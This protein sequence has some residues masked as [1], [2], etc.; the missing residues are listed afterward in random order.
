MARCETC[1]CLHPIITLSML[2]QCT[3]SSRPF[4]PSTP[5]QDTFLTCLS[6][7]PI[8]RLF[9]QL[10]RPGWNP[11]EPAL[12]PAS[13]CTLPKQPEPIPATSPCHASPTIL[14][15]NNAPTLVHLLSKL[16]ANSPSLTVLPMMLQPLSKWNSPGTPGTT[17]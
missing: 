7:I 2:Q 17:R 6:P 9:S 12:Q 16:P 1:L 5:I 3:P 10:P 8:S 13:L 15:T 14:T 11:P 4:A